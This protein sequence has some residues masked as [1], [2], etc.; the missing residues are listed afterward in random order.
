MRRTCVLLCAA[1]ITPSI[2]G[3][4]STPAPSPALPPALTLDAALQ[5]ALRRNPLLRAA[6]A[7]VD[8]TQGALDQAG[9]RPNPTLGIEQ[10]DTRR[11]TRTTTLLLT[12]PL[13]LGGKR[14]ARLG[15]ARS[16]RE[17][18]LADLASRQAEVR[19][20][21]L[22]AFFD[23]LIAQERVTV[24]AQS[25]DIAA[26][27]SAAAARRVTA[28]KVSPTE[29][30]RA[31]VAEANA[32]IELRQAQADR[33]A[34]QRALAWA[35][36]SAADDTPPPL[37]GRAESLPPPP[38][39]QAL[40]ER[41][42][43][44]PALRRARGEVQHAQAA[45]ELERARRLP[46]LGVSL[47]TKRAAQTG[48]HQPVIGL[49]IP[50]PLFDAN[51]GAQLEA[52]RRRD[53]AQALAEAEERRLRAEVLQALDQLA[54]RAGEAQALKQDVL[55]AAQSVHDAASRGFELGKFSFL[56]VLDAQRTLLQARTQYFSALAQAHRAA[57][58]LERRLGTP[59]DRPLAGT[60]P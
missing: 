24:A 17:L 28:G 38:D 10:E 31:R 6:E 14:A 52:L 43:Q 35:M 23:A 9:A 34:A 57:A 39:A 51:T 32:R 29:E 40:A 18:A 13:E 2:F 30:T 49:S 53:A 15:L 41:V 22:L 1:L 19:A 47:G 21:T 45:Y 25:V 54:A 58:E 46:D 12:Q 37:D 48:R 20:D 5:T 50:L 55:P 33:L 42:A 26:S 8:A 56:D 60:Q 4:A 27:G 44:S 16:A 59:N 7:E 36:G 3:Q 11:E